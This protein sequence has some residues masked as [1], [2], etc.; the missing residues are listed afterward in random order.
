MPSRERQRRAKRREEYIQNRNGEL[1]F[2]TMLLR[3]GV[4]AVMSR[5]LMSYELL[6]GKSSKRPISWAWPALRVLAEGRV[7]SLYQ[8]LFWSVM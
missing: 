5:I 6:R 2:G 3:G 7:A 1:E 4:Y 8:D